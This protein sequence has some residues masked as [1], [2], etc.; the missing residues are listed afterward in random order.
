MAETNLQ[1]KVT[2]AGAG[3]VA[4]DL[5]KV[6]DAQSNV[7]ATVDMT[8]KM[9]AAAKPAM[10]AL[11]EAQQRLAGLRGQRQQALQ[12]GTVGEVA[13]FTEKITEQERSIRSLVAVQAEMETNARNVAAAEN[14]AATA[15]QA[16]TDAQ[17]EQASAEA[18]D[19]ARAEAEAL[20]AFAAE[21]EGAVPAIDA[22]ADAQAK[23]NELRGQ[24]ATALEEG[25][26]VEEVSPAT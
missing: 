15:A 17:A 11:V 10:E 22:L 9:A 24:R 23:L 6:A 4:A 20:K 21:A 25:K 1:L 18:A 5:Q 19:A 3:A 26:S 12:T 8:A 2:Q 14:A 7:G 16:L 13:D